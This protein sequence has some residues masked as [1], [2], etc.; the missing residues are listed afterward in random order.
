VTDRTL[1]F[2][3]QGAGYFAVRVPGQDEVLFTRSGQFAVMPDGSLRTSDRKYE[4]LDTDGQGILVNDPATDELAPFFQVRI[5]DRQTEARGQAVGNSLYRFENE[6]TRVE[7]A[8]RVA[9]G[10]LEQSTVDVVGQM[11]EMIQAM[12]A[13]EANAQNIKN[14]NDTLSRAV[15]EIARPAR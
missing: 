14:Q 10:M 15:N 1:D 6:G 4:V 8:G 9:Q 11:V 7:A 2:A 12:R 5:F 3:I 13:Y